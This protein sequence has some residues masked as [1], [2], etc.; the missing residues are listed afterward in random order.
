MAANLVG[1]VVGIAAAFLGYGAWAIVGQ[2]I[3]IAVVSTFLI[4]FASPWRP[5]LVFSRA[6]LRSMIGFSGNVFLTRILFY[7][8]R[9]ADNLLIGRYLGPTALGPYALAYNVD[10]RA[11]QPAHMADRRGVLPRVL[12]AA[13]RSGTDRRRL[14]ARQPGDRRDHGARD[15][16]AGRRRARVRECRARRAMGGRNPGDPAARLGRAPAVAPGPQLEHP[17]GARPHEP[18]APLRRGGPRRQPDRLRCRRTVGHR[19][20]GGGVRH[21]Q[22][23]RR[24]V[25]HVADRALHRDD[26]AILRDWSRACL[27]G[28]HRDGDRGRARQSSVDPPRRRRRAAAGVAR[29]RSASSCTCRSSPGAPPSSSPRSATCCDGVAPP[30]EPASTPRACRARPG[31][32]GRGS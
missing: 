10:A 22:H 25:L 6:S 11:D 24:A 8:N 17:A 27:R 7:V 12:A 2:Q 19:R 29:A 32:S 3:V 1:G 18:V 21:L 16:R 30:T 15:A 4:W 23:H 20:G 9:N 5:H 13:E 14:G 26:P 28:V 31:W